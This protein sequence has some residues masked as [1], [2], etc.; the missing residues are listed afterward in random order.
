MSL[1]CIIVEDLQVAAD[2]LNR[3]CEKSG[4]LIVKGHFSAVPE[5]LEFLNSNV[6]D[7]IFL[8]FLVLSKNY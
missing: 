3:C 2:Y 5:A 4:Q 1:T 8:H 6:V 7:L